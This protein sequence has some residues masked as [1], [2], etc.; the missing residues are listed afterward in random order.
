MKIFFDGVDLSSSTGP[1]RFA[2]QLAAGLERAGHT[3]TTST[4][5]D[6]HLSFIERRAKKQHGSKIVQRLDGIWFKESEFHTKN[7]GIKDLYNCADGVIFQSDFDSRMVQHHWGAPLFAA[8]IIRNGGS[9]PYPTELPKALA[10]ITQEYS[11]VFSCAAHWH[12]QKRLVDCLNIFNKFKADRPDDTC[13]LIVLGDVSPLEIMKYNGTKDVFWAGEQALE[14]SL[15]IMSASNWFIHA[16]YLDHSPNVVV[17]AQAMGTPV[18]CT[19]SG[20]TSELLQ[21]GGGEII[22]EPPYDYRLLDYDDPPRL[23][24]C[25]WDPKRIIK[26]RVSWQRHM[27]T[28]TSEY[29]AFFETLLQ[30]GLCPAEVR[31]LKSQSR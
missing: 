30:G 25:N 19:N 10:E 7:T 23:N 5:C 8:R 29:I 15:Q 27:H 20:G 13:C 12:P 11:Y 2:S 6:I 17:Q 18:I 31:L 26:K 24:L 9:Y 14:T 1:N 3:V 4:I 22:T 28:V 16:A 21:Y